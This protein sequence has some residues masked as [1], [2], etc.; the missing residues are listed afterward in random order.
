MCN[1]LAPSCWRV[2][3]N[4]RLVSRLG[5]KWTERLYLQKP[6][7]KEKEKADVTRSG[8]EITTRLRYN[9]SLLTKSNWNGRKPR[10]PWVWL[11]D[12]CTERVANYSSHGSSLAT[13]ILRQWSYVGS[14][15]SDVGGNTV[16]QFGSWWTELP[17]QA[18]KMDWGSRTKSCVT[19]SMATPD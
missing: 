18:R 7:Q 3:Q 2:W 17:R 13:L 19:W 15:S 10:D 9:H 14:I 8:L 1:H 12:A 16:L 6:L 11:F 5:I 4:C